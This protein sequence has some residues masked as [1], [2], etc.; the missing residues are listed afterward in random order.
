MAST[1]FVKQNTKFEQRQRL[2][3]VT[4][5]TTTFQPVVCYRYTVYNDW[6]LF[7]FSVERA[8][9]IHEIRVI[10]VCSAISACVWGEKND[11]IWKSVVCVCVMCI[12]VDDNDVSLFFVLKAKCSF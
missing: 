8:F 2:V 11:V 4:N 12:Y 1:I 6:F 5:T 7:G 3:V 9:S 10:I